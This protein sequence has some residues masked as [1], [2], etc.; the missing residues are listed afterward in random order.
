MVI[1]TAGLFALVGNEPVIA[2]QMMQGVVMIIHTCWTKAFPPV[3]G[4]RTKTLPTSQKNGASANPRRAAQAW[5]LALPEA[6]DEARRK[7]GGRI[8]AK[9]SA[10]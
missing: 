3:E 1:G 6:A 8:G 4:V 10:L 7:D 5:I 2:T 9:K